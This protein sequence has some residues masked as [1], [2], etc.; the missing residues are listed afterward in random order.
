MTRL[1]LLAVAAVV[2]GSSVAVADGGHS[3]TFRRDGAYI[4]VNVGVGGLVFPDKDQTASRRLSVAAALR[5]GVASAPGLLLGFSAGGWTR[6][7]DEGVDVTVGAVT[8][9]ATWFP[10]GTV[11]PPARG[12]FVRGGAGLSKAIVAV[13]PFYREEYGLAAEAGLGWEFQVNGDF[14]LGAAFDW[15][16]AFLRDV[17]DADYWAGTVQ[18]TWYVPARSPESRRSPSDQ[19]SH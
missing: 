14:H 10:L 13:A 4:G 18:F 19:P 5:L 11:L 7:F 1:G 17:P 2:D 8:G 16:F 9:Q 15:Y 3:E 12:L 6:Q